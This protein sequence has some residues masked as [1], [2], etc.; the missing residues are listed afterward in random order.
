LRIGEARLVGRWLTGMI[1]AQFVDG[2]LV[3]VT[4]GAKQVLCLMFELIEI[5]TD[6]NVTVGHASL[7]RELY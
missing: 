1:P 7:L 5:G 3:A 2:F 4:D 6:R